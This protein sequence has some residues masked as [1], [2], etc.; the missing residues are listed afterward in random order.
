MINRQLELKSVPG[1]E[2]KLLEDALEANL[3]NVRYYKASGLRR[4][5]GGPR[6]SYAIVLLQYGVKHVLRSPT[7]SVWIDARGQS[8]ETP[9][10]LKLKMT[11]PEDVY[12]RITSALESAPTIQAALGQSY[13]GK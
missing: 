1:Q 9:F 8:M 2:L 4:D 12:D 13:A 7:T 6:Y 11:L 3:E 5:Q 10:N